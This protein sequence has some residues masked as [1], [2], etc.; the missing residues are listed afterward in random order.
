M[1]LY[2]EL[3]QDSTEDSEVEIEPGFLRHKDERMY[4]LDRAA[5]QKHL[6]A[7]QA[8]D[9]ENVRKFREKIAEKER[10]FRSKDRLDKIVGAHSLG[11]LISTVSL[12]VPNND[13]AILA[14]AGVLAYSLVARLA[15]GIYRERKYPTPIDNR[16]SGSTFSG[17]GPA[18]HG[19]YSPY[20]PL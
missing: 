5:E 8:I 9:L 10:K 1:A 12:F 14:A 4:L 13:K 15:L 3:E 20:C 18:G 16:N 19:H 17:W 6:A 7:K 2:T 11:A